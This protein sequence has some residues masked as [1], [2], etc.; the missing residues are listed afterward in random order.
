MT[1]QL[2]YDIIVTTVTPDNYNY[3]RYP[4]LHF[5]ARSWGN[6][7]IFSTLLLHTVI[8]VNCMVQILET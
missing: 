5:E 4:H 1:F 7:G 2:R 3:R 6:F 8:I